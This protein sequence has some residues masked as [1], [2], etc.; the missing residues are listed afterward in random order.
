MPAAPA[1]RNKSRRDS[2]CRSNSV[3]VRSLSMPTSF[4]DPVKLPLRAPAPAD[5][6]AVNI[7]RKAIPSAGASGFWTAGVMSEKTVARWERPITPLFFRK[8]EGY[9]GHRKRNPLPLGKALAAVVREIVPLGSRRAELWT[10]S[11]A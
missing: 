8:T 9:R 10:A 6:S 11:A 1:L 2:L 4:G 3:R 7:A 5:D